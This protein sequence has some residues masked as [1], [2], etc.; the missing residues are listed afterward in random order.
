MATVV[1]L[2]G[3]ARFEREFV[4]MSERLTLE[5]CVVLSLGT[6]RLPDLPGYDWES[7]PSG[8]KQRLGDVHLKKVRMADEV[9][10][11]D[12]GGYVGESTAREIALAE[13]L[14]IPVRHYSHEHDPRDRT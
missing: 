13:S 10:V 5:G 9:Y 4:E 6:F 3:S 8:I 7:D 1:T 14:G 11:I 2:C 12:P